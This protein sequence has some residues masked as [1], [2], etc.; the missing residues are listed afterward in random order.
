MRNNSIISGVFWTMGE[1]CIAQIVSF[2][3]SIVLA[4]LLSPAD[5]GV[6]AI[7]LIFISIADV[8]VSNGFGAALIQK[9]DADQLDFSTLLICSVISSIVIYF[10]I[11]F[12]APVIADFYNNK[13]IV[14][15]MRVMALRIPISGYNTIQRAYISRNML[16]KKFFFSTLGG[17]VVSAI[18]GITMAYKGLG[19]W[20]LVAQNL[21]NTVVDTIVLSITID[22]KPTFRFKIE[23]AISLMSYG[24]KVLCTSVIGTFFDQLQSLAIGKAFSSADLAYYNKGNQIP[25]LVSSNVS[26]SVMTVLFPAFANFSDDYDMIRKITRKAIRMMTYISFPIMIGLAMTARPLITL[27]LTEKWEQSIEYM[28]ILSI[29]VAFGL[30]GDTGLQTIKAIGRSDVLLKLEL[31]KKPVFLVLLVLGLNY[32]TMGVAI[33]TVIYSF[34]AMLMNFGTMGKLINYHFSDQLK[35]VVSVAILSLIM[36]ITVYICNL[37][38]FCNYILEIIF[39]TFIGVSVYIFVSLVTRSQEFIY[40]ITFIKEKLG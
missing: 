32:G 37:I 12:L 24:W 25:S 29:S 19:A 1:R 4:R 5:Y 9:K 6:V 15:L 34:Y 33:T 31:V 23:R 38:P 22:W 27:L 40:L 13:N 36:G 8:F 35:D 2:I 20:A 7:L 26:N 11:Y 21:G 28:K 14:L 39:K 17:T 18:I 16:F 30:V 10:I 3:V